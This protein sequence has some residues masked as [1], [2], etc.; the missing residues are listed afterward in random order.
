MSEKGE[1]VGNWQCPW[2]MFL[3]VSKLYT[4]FF[5]SRFVSAILCLYFHRGPRQATS[6]VVYSKYKGMYGRILKSLIIVNLYHEMSELKLKINTIRRR[7]NILPY[8]PLFYHTF[9]Y[10]TD[11]NQVEISRI[12]KQ[13]RPLSGLPVFSPALDISS[14]CRIL[15]RNPSAPVQRHLPEINCS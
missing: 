5:F 10:S 13:T 4:S 8:I 15:V 3:K 11:F 6:L 9:L 2:L 14:P 12:N 7:F 1:G